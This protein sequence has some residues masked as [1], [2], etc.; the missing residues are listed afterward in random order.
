MDKKIL[1]VSGLVPGEIYVTIEKN[2]GY[3][4]E[5]QDIEQIKSTFYVYPA[6]QY[7][8]TAGNLVDNF[9]KYV[10]ASDRECYIFAVSK[11]AGKYKD[12]GDTYSII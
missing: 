6:S 12:D 7:H 4:F 10:R 9:G 5:F 8:G 11:I 3:V 1:S 2:A